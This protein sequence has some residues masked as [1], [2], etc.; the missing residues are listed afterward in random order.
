MKRRVR[1]QPTNP[2]YTNEPAIPISGIA[3]KAPVQNASLGN[4]TPKMVDKHPAKMSGVAEFVSHSKPT[5]G[6][7]HINLPKLGTTAKQP[8][9]AGKLRLSGHSGAHRIGA[10]K[11]LKGI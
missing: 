1:T 9:Q 6:N 2:Y 3:D 11:K 5:K 10:V 4:K 7:S 8:A